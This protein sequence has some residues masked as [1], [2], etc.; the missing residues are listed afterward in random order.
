MSQR[1]TPVISS[2]PRNSAERETAPESSG[3]PGAVRFA[4]EYAGQHDRAAA[5]SR[6]QSQPAAVGLTKARKTVGDELTTSRTTFDEEPSISDGPGDCQQPSLQEHPTLKAFLRRGRSFP[7]AA[8]DDDVAAVLP[9]AAIAPVGKKSEGDSPSQQQASRRWI[10][11]DDSTPSTPH[12]SSTRQRSQS[13]SSSSN[14]SEGNSNRPSIISLNK[15]SAKH[16]HHPSTTAEG[17]QQLQDS[18]AAKLNARATEK[19]PFSEGA[20]LLQD[21]LSAATLC[22]YQALTNASFRISS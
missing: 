11:Y 10:S 1:A 9:P 14:A 22:P 18:L 8:R 4:D 5:Y 13:L 6:H 21:S 16:H 19:L 17:M 2:K 7:A 12:E 3:L 20:R 15:S